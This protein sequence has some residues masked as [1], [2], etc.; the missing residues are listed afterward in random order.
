[1][2]TL[3]HLRLARFRLFYENEGIKVYTVWE[4]SQIWSKRLS[5][6][7]IIWGRLAARAI[8]WLKDSFMTPAI[9]LPETSRYSAVSLWLSCAFV[10][11]FFC[12]T[13]NRP[14]WI[15]NGGNIWSTLFVLPFYI[16]LKIWCLIKRG[17][18]L[19]LSACPIDLWG[20]MW[21]SESL[22]SDGGSG[23]SFAMGHLVE[24][25]VSLSILPSHTFTDCH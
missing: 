5:G 20:I 2:S 10:L 7:V 1:M 14:F 24:R 15:G 9:T 23:N 11:V 8:D 22:E 17:V 21:Q 25:Y 19:K 3:S 16:T 12:I 4:V 6:A 18:Y 13:K